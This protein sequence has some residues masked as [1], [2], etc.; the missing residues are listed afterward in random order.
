MGTRCVIGRVLE[1]GVIAF[2][3]CSHDG[4]VDGA[5]AMLLKHY[6]D[7]AKVAELVALGDI[8]GVEAWPAECRVYDDGVKE[9]PV[10]LA[11]FVAEAREAGYGYLFTSDGWQVLCGSRTR[12]VPLAHAVAVE[13]VVRKHGDEDSAVLAHALALL[14]GD[15]DKAVA[16]AKAERP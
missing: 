3:W 2:A 10:S 9:A 7:P 12:W 1:D 14:G 16:M 15:V 4:Y 6:A 8:S 11:G 5:G 13:A